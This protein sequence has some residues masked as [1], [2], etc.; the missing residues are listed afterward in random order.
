MD[1][2]SAVNN[3]PGL[4]LLFLPFLFSAKAACWADSAEAVAMLMPRLVRSE[5]CYCIRL[6]KR[7]LKE[8]HLPW[9]PA[10]TT[11][12]A[13]RLPDYLYIWAFVD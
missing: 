12:L 4:R 2:A 1:H 7:P 11:K 3:S 13:P 10:S 5:P 9:I 6:P 8:Y